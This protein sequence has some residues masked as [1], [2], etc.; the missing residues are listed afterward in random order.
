MSLLKTMHFLESRDDLSEC[1]QS[2]IKWSSRQTELR[3]VTV[4]TVGLHGPNQP[5]ERLHLLLN[6]LFLL[7]TGEEIHQPEMTMDK[8]PIFLPHVLKPFFIITSHIRISESINIKGN[9]ALVTEPDEII[10]L[11]ESI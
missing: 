5:E 10:K 1:N 3:W 7:T 4:K 2:F 11:L 6:I 8:Q 9:I